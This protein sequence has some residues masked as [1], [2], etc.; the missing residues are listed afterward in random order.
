LV[1]L[2]LL[3]MNSHIIL[4]GGC[5]QLI[6]SPRAGKSSVIHQKNQLTLSTV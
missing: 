6:T 3:P 1:P 5:Q 4:L 2:F